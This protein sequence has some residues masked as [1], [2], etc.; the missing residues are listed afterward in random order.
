MNRPPS[1]DGR[2]GEE[3]RRAAR[4]HEARRTAAD[5][6]AAAFG[7]LHQD[8]ADERKGDQRLNDQQECEHDGLS[9]EEV[10]GAT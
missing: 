9:K 10:R 5:A 6:E 3:I 4:G 2:A 1:T 8:D 7:A